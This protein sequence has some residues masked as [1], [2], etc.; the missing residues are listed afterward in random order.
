[1]NQVT[2]FRNAIDPLDHETTH[3]KDVCAH[4]KKTFGKWP[5]TAKIYHE[6]ID[7]THDVT[8]HC[9]F[10]I[11][12]LQKLNGHFFVVVWPED[13]ITI[14]VVV[15]IVVAA[16]AIGAAFL[17]RPSTQGQPESSP[18]NQ[19]ASRQNKARPN[20]RIPDI[21]GTVRSTPD[22]LAFPYRTF[23]NNQEVETCFMGIGRGAYTIIDC[24]DDQTPINEI[25]GEFVAVYPPGNSPNSAVPA[26]QTTFGIAP[27][28]VP[29][30][31]SVQQSN[32]VNG[33]LVRATNSGQVEAADNVAF[34]YGGT[35]L[36]NDSN[37]DF[38]EYFV[39]STMAAPSF[40]SIYANDDNINASD[41]AE[42][43]HS[44][45][46]A[47]TYEILSVTSSEI[48]LSNPAAVN[49]NWNIL[50]TFSGQQSTFHHS[51][52]MTSQASFSDGP[53]IINVPNC[54]E[55]WAN[56]VAQSGLYYVDSG[57]TQHKLTITIQ[58][59]VQAI[60]STLTPFGD[61]I[62]GSINVVGSATDRVTCGSTLKLKLP[63]R[64]PVQV[65]VKR[66]T[67]LG[68][69]T[70]YS[71]SQDIQWRDLY[72]VSYIG[73][74]GTA[75]VESALGIGSLVGAFTDG[76]GAVI[77]TLAIG[78]GAT[79][80]V[81][82]GATQLQ[83]GIDD[84]KFAD[85]TGSFNVTV[86]GPTSWTGT[87]DGKA[88]PWNTG[89]NPSFPFGIADGSAPVVALT[90][91]TAGNTV[92]V[93]VNSGTVSVFS[94]FGSWGGNGDP[95]VI[96]ASLRGTTGTLFPTAYM[97]TSA[98]VQ[99]DI[100]FG[101]ITT[102]LAITAVTPDA[103]TIKSRKINLLVT[104]NLPTWNRNATTPA[105]T[106]SIPTNNAAD[107]FCAMALDPFI[108]RRN[109]VEL[110]VPGI[111][112]VADSAYMGSG[113]T[114]G[115][116]ATYF[117]TFL[118]TEFCYTFDDSKVSFEES[119]SYIAQA[120]DC[121][122]FRSA[123]KIGLSFEKLTPDSTI[124][125]N[126]RNKLPKSETRTVSFG[127]LNDNDGVN[128]DYVDPNA[129]N[130]PTVDTTLTLYFPVDQ[131]AVNPKKVTSIG[132]RNPVQAKINGWRLYNKIL[133]ANT[134]TEFDA[135]HEAALSIVNDRI[136]VA[137]NTRTG[138]QDGD[139]HAVDGLTITT[140]QPNDLPGSVAASNDPANWSVPQGAATMTRSRPLGNWFNGVLWSNPGVP[141]GMPSD[142][143]ITGI[144]PVIVLSAHHD[145]ASTYFRY[146]PDQNLAFTSSTE[147]FTNPSD[148]DNTTFSSTLF[149]GPNL[150]TDLSVLEGQQ[151]LMLLNASLFLDG[152][153]DSATASAVGFAVYYTSATPSIDTRIAA[154]FAVT[155]GL[156]WSLPLAVSTT[157][158]TGT[159]T[160]TG[161][162]SVYTGTPANY[163]LFLQLYDG[164]V[165]AI[166][167]F[168]LADPYQL[169][170][171][172]EPRLPLC[173]DARN[174]A[175][176]TYILCK[177]DPS[178]TKLP[179][180]LTQKDPQDNSTFKLT[181]INYSDSYYSHDTDFTL[182]VLLAPVVGY[183]PQGYI[184][185]GNVDASGSTTTSSGD[186]YDGGGYSGSGTSGGNNPDPP[187]TTGPGGTPSPD[188]AS[189][190]DNEILIVTTGPTIPLLAHVPTPAASLKL[191]WQGNRQQYGIDFSVTD[192]QITAITFVPSVGDNLIA[193][194]R[195]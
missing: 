31:V 43:V 152:L 107:I 66:V 182:G 180:L 144:Y 194:Y 129:P 149:Y 120:I 73:G 71:Y 30:V 28:I 16:V 153:S 19:L 155:S 69:N 79:Y 190:A 38:T 151:I 177:N 82:T 9:E 181:A 154:P 65:T 172:T 100:D 93:K 35:I 62:S 101:N 88:M 90:G 80:K 89:G 128:Y 171:Q 136:L 42:H 41:P 185:E 4:L 75:Q 60:D 36:T 183:G 112:A 110:D 12:H 58:M 77:K 72:A 50:A 126:H 115:E 52:K 61:I 74:P 162:A 164:T 137:D 140:S 173:P 175:R 51:F 47:G 176:T 57:G 49:S 117:G 70:S 18:N 48:V 14:L 118:M 130:Y 37:L 45:S 94:G 195:Y 174:Y 114:D 99:A 56:F 17:L 64:G 23:Q 13:P 11:D 25:A 121:I 179:F 124:L 188:S 187:V 87:V 186:G 145:Q 26:P 91:L 29:Q 165:E 139:I 1:M 113:R 143:V 160:A 109:I 138:T 97:L 46:L 59:D 96:T 76:S 148:P 67:P 158:V 34:G 142:A 27:A 116:I 169:L 68:T 105:F 156:A 178:A 102:V 32:A 127:T 53:F 85:N 39:A 193:D 191:F 6:R 163:I 21:V 24:K 55:V 54:D 157:G 133:F 132:V 168:P 40:I 63:H 83:L 146:G 141:L 125:Y 44:V 111:Y 86:T 22:L 161:S 123:S 15:A 78:A 134:Q 189:F 170:L 192:A 167:C 33:Q 159:G 103:L 122:A 20:E 131:S 92:A 108:G 84:D 98:G 3:V 95:S 8:P 5:D 2:I 106:G 147:T 135:T 81:P 166:G 184:G 150:G 10:D 7:A 119:A 104:R